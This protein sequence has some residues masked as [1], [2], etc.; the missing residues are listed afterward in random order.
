[1]AFIIAEMLHFLLIILIQTLLDKTSFNLYVTQ[2]ILDSLNTYYLLLLS[3]S[4]P[5]LCH[6]IIPL[7]F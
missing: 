7:H 3:I 4:P 2:K 5:I 6:F 1:M